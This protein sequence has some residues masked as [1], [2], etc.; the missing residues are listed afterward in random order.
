MF[1][2]NKKL[3]K[4]PPPPAALVRATPSL[5]ELSS[6]TL[7]WPE[8]FVEI[9]ADDLP[10][11]TAATTNGAGHHSNG[12]ANGY[13]ATPH[14]A[15]TSVEFS[16]VP[17]FHMPFRTADAQ[18]GPIAT[19]YASPTPRAFE[20]PP[21][22]VP[23][24]PLPTRASNTSDVRRKKSHARHRTQPTFNIMVRTHSFMATW[25]IGNFAY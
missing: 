4:T 1:R 8:G 21:A 25:Y 3:A 22:Q 11:A 17:V 18:G 6:P 7:A 10:P 9:T 5:P 12:H 15:K 14:T 23:V 16:P 2:K 20:P 24:P 13:P 19:L